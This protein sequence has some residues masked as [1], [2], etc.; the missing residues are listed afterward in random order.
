MVLSSGRFALLASVA[1]QDFDHDHN[2]VTC[3]AVVSSNLYKIFAHA[4]D[5]LGC[6]MC[7]S[8]GHL[9]LQWFSDIGTLEPLVSVN[10]CLNELVGRQ[11]PRHLWRDR[12]ALTTKIARDGNPYTCREF[13]E[14]YENQGLAQWS[15]AKVPDSDKEA[16]LSRLLGPHH[17]LHHCPI[18]MPQSFQYAFVHACR[19]LWVPS[20]GVFVSGSDD[21]P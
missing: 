9:F 5:C 2:N 8:D 20:R 7:T 13:L 1:N 11:L 16:I 12:G 21:D 19:Y 17:Q 6:N 4:K 3:L 18:V 14:W 15:R 10:A